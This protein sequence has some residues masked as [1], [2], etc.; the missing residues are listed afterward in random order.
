MAI[1]FMKLILVA[2]KRLSNKN[3]KVLQSVHQ[4]LSEELCFNKLF[5]ESAR[6]LVRMQAAAPNSL[7]IHEI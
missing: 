7:P 4:I 2:C 5:L 1:N 6:K 3:K